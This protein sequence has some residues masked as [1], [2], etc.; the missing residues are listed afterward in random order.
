[1]RKFLTCWATSITLSIFG[2]YSATVPDF[3]VHHYCRSSKAECKNCL[4]NWTAVFA[5]R[6][7]DKSCRTNVVIKIHE[8][9]I[10]FDFWCFP[11]RR[12]HM[13]VCQIPPLCPKTC[14]L[15]LPASRSRGDWNKAR[16]LRASVR[17][18]FL[19]TSRRICFLTW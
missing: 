13:C 15:A 7:S 12:S 4:R 14:H 1:M 17:V 2:Q 3:L 9:E 11:H 10:D 16:P 5:L 6:C 19:S 18:Y 8:G